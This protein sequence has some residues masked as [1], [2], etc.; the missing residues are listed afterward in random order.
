MRER[1]AHRVTIFS[2]AEFSVGAAQGLCGFCDFLVS[3]SPTMLTAPVLAV[4]EAKR[5]D[6]M[7]GV[8]QCIA[9]VDKTLGIL[10][11]RTL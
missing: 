1:S 7:A 5:E 11:H 2:G 4:I 10:S 3:R 8:A 6:L 9:D